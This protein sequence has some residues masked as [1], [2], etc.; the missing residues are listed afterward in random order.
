MSKVLAGW[1]E[2]NLKARYK[3]LSFRATYFDTDGKVRLEVKAKRIDRTHSFVVLPDLIQSIRG[4]HFLFQNTR[5]YP[6]IEVL[7][8]AEAHV[9]MLAEWLMFQIHQRYRRLT[10]SLRHIEHAMRITVNHGPEF[11][12]T[13]D[14]V[15]RL[16]ANESFEDSIL[17]HSLAGCYKHLNLSPQHPP[18]LT[19]SHEWADW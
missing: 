18:A 12:I 3:L 9:M 16:L 13:N 15:E 19:F 11:Q 2:G 14:A 1:F 8:K 10:I 4:G 5:F 7:K 6:H 17:F